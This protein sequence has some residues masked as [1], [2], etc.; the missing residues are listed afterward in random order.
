[1]YEKK[2]ISG[3]P[4]FCQDCGCETHEL[5]AVTQE[6]KKTGQLQLCADCKVSAKVES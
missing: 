2:F 5:Y 3:K 4:R 6:D 1:M